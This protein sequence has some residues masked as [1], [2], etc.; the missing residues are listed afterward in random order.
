MGASHSDCCKKEPVVQFPKLIARGLAMRSLIASVLVGTAAG[1]AVTAQDALTYSFDGRVGLG[2]LS[3]T[4]EGDSGFQFHGLVLRTE[5]TGRLELEPLEGFRIGAIARVSSQ[6]GEQSYYQPLRPFVPARREF[7][8]TDLDLAV[9]AA[10]PVVTLS[11]GEMETAFDY[12]TLEVGNGS[13]IL[14]GG[15][16]LWMNLGDAAGSTGYRGELFG[17]GPPMT[18]DYRTLRAE[19][20]IGEFTASVSQSK[21]DGSTSESQATGLVW[22]GEIADVTLFAGVGY[23]DGSL[24][25]FKSFS[26]GATVEGLSLIVNK[27][28]RDPKRIIDRREYE[29]DY[30]GYSLA[31]ESGAL[32]VGFASSR[33]SSPQGSSRLFDGNA[34]AIWASWKARENATVSVELSENDYSSGESTRKASIAV[35]MDF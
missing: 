30:T 35:E 14:D 28:K 26:L 22:R 27:I 17:Y 10:L 34:Q 29:T 2:Y 16:A 24:D 31:Y 20:T 32:T 5:G 3:Q 6:K 12:A 23:D 9:Y 33:Q 19:V 13:S 11:Y 15:N 21:A 4:T 18:Q 8:G 25:E 1:S 7:D